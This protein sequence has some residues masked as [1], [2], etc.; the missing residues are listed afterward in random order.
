MFIGYGLGTNSFGSSD[1]IFGNVLALGCQGVGM[2][3]MM[4][5]IILQ[6]HRGYT[7]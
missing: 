2:S 6:V 4:W 1:Q 3:I 7:L 5:A